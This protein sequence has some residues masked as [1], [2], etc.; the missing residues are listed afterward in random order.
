LRLSLAG[1][2][3]ETAPLKLRERLALCPADQERILRDLRQR[4]H[5]VE[6]LILSTCNRIEL[7]TVGAEGRRGK[8]ASELFAT[9]A[10]RRVPDLRDHLYSLEGLEAARHLLEVAA[11]IDSMVLGEREVVAQVKEA[12][13][14]ARQV[15]TLGTVLTRLTDAAL[16]ASKEVR[17]QTR[18]D[19]GHISLA[20][21]AVDL[22]RREF[23]DLSAATILILGAGKTSEL[24]VKRLMEN[25]PKRLLVANRT[26]TRAE[27]L[28]GELGGEALPMQNL[29][30][31]VAQADVVVC[32][33]GAPHPILRK[34]GLFK[35]MQQRPNRPLVLIDLAVPRDIEPTARTIPNVVLYDLD[36]LKGIVEETAAE[37][38]RELPRAREIVN[39]HAAAFWQWAGALAFGPTVAALR[40]R[41]EQ[42]RAAQ[43]E[44]FL[45]RLGR[46]SSSQRKALHL[47]TKRLTSRLLDAPLSSLRARAA[48]GDRLRYLDMLRTLFL[49]GDYAREENMPSEQGQSKKE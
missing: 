35:L 41:A 34:P 11:G 25:R 48:D 29:D 49:E 9:I 37:R 44:E 3:H 19:R 22:A 42:I 12:A 13:R 21:V 2:N 30:P 16:S 38:R 45:P 43:V 36:D 8:T 18:I 4:K 47:L 28:A 27:R 40:Q 15:G 32:S 46:L 6:A 7:Y 33:T 24:T 31:G 5:P 20:S 10:R 39:A 26:H 1:V 14:Q 23:G 17:T